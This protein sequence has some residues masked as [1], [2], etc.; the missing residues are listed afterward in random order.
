MEIDSLIEKANLLIDDIITSDKEKQCTNNK[1]TSLW[2]NSLVKIV[3]YYVSYIIEYSSYYN[4]YD[5]DMAVIYGMLKELLI[6]LSITLELAC[7][8]CLYV[9]IMLPVC[10]IY[11]ETSINLAYLILNFK[12]KNELEQ[13]R[14]RGLKHT[15]TYAETI[16]INANNRGYMSEW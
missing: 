15:L 8:G 6:K 7:K 3:A 4:S 10:R 1:F 11:L 9:N 5:K 12:N 16:S 2:C 13:Y 14:L